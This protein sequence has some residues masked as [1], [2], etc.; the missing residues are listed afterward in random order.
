MDPHAHWDAVYR[1]RAPDQV[2]WFQPEARL[3][4]D[5]ISQANPD[6]HVSI[7]DVGGGAS[8]LVDGLLALGYEQLTVLDISGAA[9]QHARQRLGSAAHRVSWM[10]ADVLRV[11][12]PAG[13]IDVWHDRAVFHFLTDA[14][15]RH[16]YVSQVRRLVRPGGHVLVAT[17]AEDGPVRCS[18]LAVARYSATDLHGEFGEGFQLLRSTRE[19]HVTP[20][21]V[22]QAFTYCLCRC[23]PPQ[24]GRTAA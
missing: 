18:G 15:S 3:S 12:L 7:L 13:S 8:T 6:R 5:F 1:Q 9:L 16:R 2:S 17:F 10:E 24:W 14:A 23:D 21:G 20:G 11:G 4:L 19:E 22:R